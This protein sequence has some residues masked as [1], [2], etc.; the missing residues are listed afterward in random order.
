MNLFKSICALAATLFF[1][2]APC[3]SPCQQQCNVLSLSGGG[4]R[5]VIPLK[6]LEQLQTSTGFNPNKDVDIYA[7]T[8]AG[9]ITAVL[10]AAGMSVSEGIAAFKEVTKEVFSD[11]QSREDTP[12]YNIQKL[13]TALLKQFKKV[14]GLDEQTTLGDLPF[15]IIIG[16]TRLKAPQWSPEL[17][18]SLTEEGKKV[19]VIDAILRSIAAPI[20]FSS[21]QGYIDGGAS[22]LQDPSLIA[23]ATLISHKGL[24][25]LRMLSLGT[26]YEKRSIDREIN[27]GRAE[28]MPLF[29]PLGQDCATLFSKMGSS[30]L[31][32]ERF[33][34]IDFLFSSLPPLDDYQAIPKLLQHV[35]A[36]SENNQT[37]WTGYCDWIKSTFLNQNSFQQPSLASQ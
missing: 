10:L 27:W 22:G 33:L 15:P 26:G 1:S 19:R 16:T 17:I 9:A 21:Y 14:E 35:E 31:L 18:S 7:G 6:V 36:F 30:Q 8:S 34:D 13:K 5:G 23:L 32:K 11:P 29:I 20:Y 24:N 25:T 12:K 37:S 3:Q 2:L 4:V 28:W